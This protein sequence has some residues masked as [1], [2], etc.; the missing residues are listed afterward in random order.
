MRS[1]ITKRSEQAI[2]RAERVP[3]RSSAILT[4]GARMTPAVRVD[5]LAALAESPRGTTSMGS[6]TL[7]DLPT[8]KKA[9][10]TAVRSAR[11]GGNRRSR[12]GQSN[13]T[14]VAV[15]WSAVR[16]HQDR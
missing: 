14:A 4:T 10:V 15:D 1:R 8:D 11:P 13:V 9:P 6:G 2:A 3:S 7:W 5:Q 12:M 16:R